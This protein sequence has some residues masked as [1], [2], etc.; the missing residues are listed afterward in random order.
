MSEYLIGIKSNSGTNDVVKNR[1]SFRIRF[2][3]FETN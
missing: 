1:D 3:I 2:I